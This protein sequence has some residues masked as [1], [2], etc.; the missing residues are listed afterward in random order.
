MQTES[1]WRVLLLNAVPAL[2]AA[3]LLACP[4]S[5][6]CAPNDNTVAGPSLANMAPAEIARLV[7]ADG[8]T[9]V[10]RTTYPDMPLGHDIGGIELY[11]MPEPASGRICSV[12]ALSISVDKAQAAGDEIRYRLAAGSHHTYFAVGLDAKA[13]DGVALAD[14]CHGTAVLADFM[15]RT[16]A[17]NLFDAPSAE[18]ARA[19]ASG[20]EM[21][22]AAAGRKADPLP[23]ALACESA[24][25]HFCEDP[26]YALAKVLERS[27]EAI[28]PC[29]DAQDRCLTADGFFDGHSSCALRIDF[30]AEDM[31]RIDRA[32]LTC[33]WEPVF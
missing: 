7:H 10:A 15:S 27:I 30:H 31:D 22:K 8:K 14:A 32:R 29:P 4:S 9:W 23:F 21:L 19:G 2:A 12:D 1:K 28:K 6:L 24:I 17:Q 18:I 3:S 5:A 20:V 11:A 13:G 25:E 16:G 33:A 26:R